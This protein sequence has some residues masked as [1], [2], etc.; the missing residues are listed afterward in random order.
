MHL[1]DLHRNN[2]LFWYDDKGEIHA[3]LIDWGKIKRIFENDHDKIPSD[4]DVEDYVGAHI[5]ILCV[6]FSPNIPSITTA[7][8]EKV[9]RRVARSF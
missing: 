4:G 5:T 6:K 7:S 1:S 9:G 2:V 8:G 3:N